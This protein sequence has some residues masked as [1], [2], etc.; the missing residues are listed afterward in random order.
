ML[1]SK[2]LYYLP[3]QGQ[4]RATSYAL[5][6][7]RLVG[8]LFLSICYSKTATQTHTRNSFDLPYLP[9]V[10]GLGKCR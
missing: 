7:P 5:N 4:T 10:L 3:V 1:E 9:R 2:T 6:I 8:S